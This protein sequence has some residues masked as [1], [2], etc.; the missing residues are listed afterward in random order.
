MAS[1]KDIIETMGETGTLYTRTLGAR[2]ATTGHPAVTYSVGTSV[3]IMID[4]TGTTETYN[5]A[6]RETTKL[7][8][9][10]VAPTV[11]VSHMDRVTVQSISYEVV[12]TPTIKY[13]EG[14]AAFKKLALTR[15]TA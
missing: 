15:V 7:Y 10:Y 3:K 13:H 6:G 8:T 5:P 12:S 11:T 9:G 4:D 2:N 14:Y 1:V